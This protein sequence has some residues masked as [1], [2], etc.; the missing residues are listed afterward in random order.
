MLFLS[1]LLLIY[2][3]QS[4]EAAKNGIL[5]CGKAVIPA[6]FP[7]FV[8]NGVLMRLGF[9]DDIGRLLKAPMK[10]LFGMSGSCAMAIMTGMICGYP[11]GAKAAS[12]LYKSG[13]CSKGEAERLLAYVNNASPA[14]LIA[15]VGASMLGSAKKGAIIYIIQLLSAFAVGMIMKP[16][17]NRARKAIS[18]SKDRKAIYK[19]DH[20][21]GGAKA[22]E[23]GSKAKVKTG[24]GS[25]TESETRAKIGAISEAEIGANR[26][27]GAR[28]KARVKAETKTA[29]EAMAEAE[30]VSK[31]TAEAETR[32]MSRAKTGSKTAAESKP[33]AKAKTR[34][35][36]IAH[37]TPEF[38]MNMLTDSIQD[39]ALSVI[40]VCGSVVFFSVIVHFILKADILPRLIACIAC[41]LLE[42]TSASSAASEMLDPIQSLVVVAFSIGWSG[43]SVHIQTGAVIGKELSM[44]KYYMGK[45]MSCVFCTIA[46]LVLIKLGIF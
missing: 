37:A 21:Q 7:F 44:S 45:A 4:S 17:T 36:A 18:A 12:E 20:P 23:A 27:T 38:C 16:R 28:A 46:A 30:T 39:S 1:G 24:M 42:V 43:L 41:G 31:A 5:L 6:L 25:E 15:G 33:E 35:A 26:E 34:S 10:K 3:P 19:S 13:R 9:A 8:I 32:S 40:P 29:S 14:F 2:S 11:S 22:A